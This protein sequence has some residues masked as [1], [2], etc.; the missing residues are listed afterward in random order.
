MF[1]RHLNIKITTAK[2]ICIRNNN[3]N[4]GGA[5]GEPDAISVFEERLRGV[6]SATSKLT[7]NKGDLDHT[8]E[9]W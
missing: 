6:N 3:W 7:K 4:Y 8:V 5:D 9:L 1:I 2:S